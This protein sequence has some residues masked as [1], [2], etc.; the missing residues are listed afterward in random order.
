MHVQCVANWNNRCVRW[1]LTPIC[2]TSERVHPRFYLAN[3][4]NANDYHQYFLPR[5]QLTPTLCDFACPNL[6]D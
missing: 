5:I 6:S 2:A 4:R 1:L 3:N